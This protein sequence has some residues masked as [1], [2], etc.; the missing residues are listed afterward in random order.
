MIGVAVKVTL[1]PAQIVLALAAMLTEGVSI[2]L[3]AITMALLVTVETE[4][5]VTLDVNMHL[6]TSPFDKVVELKEE[7]LVPT[8]TLFT[9][10]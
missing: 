5:Q 10:H 9:C 8:F 6:T 3:T 1:V 7:L 4:V 2:G